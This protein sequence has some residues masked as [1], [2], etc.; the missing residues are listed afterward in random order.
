MVVVGSKQEQRS[1]RKHIKY[2][3]TW[4]LISGIYKTIVSRLEIQHLWFT[5]HTFMNLLPIPVK[6]CRLMKSGL[7]QIILFEAVWNVETLKCFPQQNCSSTHKVPF[8]TQ[9]CWVHICRHHAPGLP[10]FPHSAT[11]N[12]ELGA[13]G[14][15]STSSPSRNSQNVSSLAETS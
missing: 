12:Y 2:L 3:E 1:I 9:L 13:E 14:Y 6:F 15:P 8:L 11:T 7:L 4:D 10:I 5:I